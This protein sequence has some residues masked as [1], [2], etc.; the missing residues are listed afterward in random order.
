MGLSFV[1]S[2]LP[3]RKPR[4]LLFLLLSI[5]RHVIALIPFICLHFLLI[6]QCLKTNN[7][8]KFYSSYDFRQ[9]LFFKCYSLRLPEGHLIISI[10]FFLFLAVGCRQSRVIFIELFRLDIWTFWTLKHIMLH[11]V[12]FLAVSP[13]SCSNR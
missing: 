7:T 5:V 6:G 12:P 10:N 9:Q 13:G 4:F 3:K 8:A 2:K 1:M 11:S